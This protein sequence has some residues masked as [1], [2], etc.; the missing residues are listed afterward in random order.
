MKDAGATWFEHDHRNAC[1]DLGGEGVE[2]LTQVA[3][4][5]IKK[6]KVV[7]RTAAAD[8]MLRNGNGRSR[9]LKHTMR[10]MEHIWVEVVIPGIGPQHNVRLR[11]CRLPSV[12]SIPLP[13]K[14]SWGK[15]RDLA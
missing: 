14:V 9:C 13:A 3:L 4:R 7:K 10:S 11:I 15:L 1:H 5:S 6:A 12:T 8:V 2:D